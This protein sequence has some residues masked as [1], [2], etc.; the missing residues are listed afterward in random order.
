MG[1]LRVRVPETANAAAQQVLGSGIKV[2]IPIKEFTDID[3]LFMSI[4]EKKQLLH[5]FLED[6]EVAHSGLYELRAEQLPRIGPLF[7]IRGE[8]AMTK[9]V[10][11]VPQEILSFPLPVG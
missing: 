11:P 9:E 4:K 6:I 2:T 8:D 5:M 10:L 7:S 3:L 1:E